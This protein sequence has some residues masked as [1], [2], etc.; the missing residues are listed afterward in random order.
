MVHG[1][2]AALVFIL[3]TGRSGSTSLMHMLNQ[4]PGFYIAGE[5]DGMTVSLREAYTH[6]LAREA[7]ELPMND[8]YHKRI[9]E[10]QLRCAL[11]RFTKIAIGDPRDITLEKVAITDNYS[12]NSACTE[13]FLLLL[14]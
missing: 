13:G 10:N 12:P 11:Q 5:N 9:N 3:A 8:H 2:S 4:I 1:P 6:A 14:E 7:D